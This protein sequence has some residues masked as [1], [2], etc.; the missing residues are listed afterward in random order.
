[1]H[2]LLKNN[3]QTS[4]AFCDDIL[5]ELVKQHLEPV[6]QNIDHETPYEYVLS[7]VGDVEKEYW[8]CALGPAAEEVYRKHIVVC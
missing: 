7:I 8:E 6:L 2:S 3:W 4:V 5:Q 1:M